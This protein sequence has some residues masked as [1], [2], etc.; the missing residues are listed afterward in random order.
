MTWKE[1]IRKKRNYFSASDYDR[2][3]DQIPSSVKNKIMSDIGN[4]M[5]KYDDL[6]EEASKKKFAD[7]EMELEEYTFRALVAT[8]LAMEDRFLTRNLMRRGDFFND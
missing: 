8:I 7:K 2:F 4:L 5:D 1:E 3:S 6:L